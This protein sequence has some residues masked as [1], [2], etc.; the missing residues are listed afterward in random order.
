MREWFA[1]TSFMLRFVGKDSTDSTRRCNY[2][3]ALAKY[4]C[5]R[6]IFNSGMLEEWSRDMHCIAKPWYPTTDYPTTLRTLRYHQYWIYGRYFP[7]TQEDYLSGYPRYVGGM[8]RNAWHIYFTRTP[9][10]G[11]DRPDPGKA[12]SGQSFVFWSRLTSSALP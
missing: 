4:K 9:G 2:A 11:S 1:A 5:C 8:A 12:P 7:Q 3:T 6:A 10:D